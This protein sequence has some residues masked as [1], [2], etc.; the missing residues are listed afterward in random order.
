GGRLLGDPRASVSGIA[1]LDRA[2][3]KDLSFLASP[4]YSALFADSSAGIVL[5]TPAL[6]ET[7]GR[8]SAR[9]VVARPHEALLSLIPRFHR[10]R[11][12]AAGVHPT[13]S[14]G[15]GARLGRD[16]SIGPY[17]IVGEGVVLG[18]RATVG[19]HTVIGAGVTIGDDVHL[20]PTV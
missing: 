15:A 6:A 18:E 13:A 12:R 17:A 8:A 7:A 4:K 14:I 2:R 5:V 16:V 3:A 19:A 20:Y 1:P 9:I 10:P 11:P